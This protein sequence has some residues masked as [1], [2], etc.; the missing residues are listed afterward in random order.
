METIANPANPDAKPWFNEV[1]HFKCPSRKERMSRRSAKLRVMIP[2]GKGVAKERAKAM[3]LKDPLPRWLQ[4]IVEKR[5][6][7]GE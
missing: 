6:A 2:L 5:C 3:A 7:A 4:Y 1:C